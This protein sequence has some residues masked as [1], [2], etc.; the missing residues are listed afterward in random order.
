MGIIDSDFNLMICIRNLP[1]L[2]VPFILANAIQ[3]YGMKKSLITLSLLCCLGQLLITLGLTYLNYNLCFL[4]RLIFGFS[5]S[6]TVFQ[7]I[8]LC[9]WFDSN[10]LPLVFGL[11]L[12]LVKVVRAINDNL[13]SIFYNTTQ[14]LPSFFWLGFSLCLGSLISAYYLTTIHVEVIENNLKDKVKDDLPLPN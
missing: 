13:A 12:F 9:F 5:D 11:L 1:S 14:S 6:V 2:F 10:R 8:V 4:G 7:H 3:K